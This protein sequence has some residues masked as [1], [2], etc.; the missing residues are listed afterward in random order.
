MIPCHLH[1][2]QTVIGDLILISLI[3]LCDVAMALAI[4]AKNK[5]TTNEIPEAAKY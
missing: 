2:K 3:C 1:L 5:E 4:L